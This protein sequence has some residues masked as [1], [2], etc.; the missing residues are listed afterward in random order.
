[1]G[2]W[3]QDR[4]DLI[5]REHHRV[6]GHQII[7][8]GGLWKARCLLSGRAA[9]G[10]LIHA[11]GEVTDV[12]ETAQGIH[13]NL[14]TLQQ[15]LLPSQHLEYWLD[16]QQHASNRQAADK[17]RRLRRA[18]GLCKLRCS[19]SFYIVITSARLAG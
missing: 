16:S 1:M 13:E 7:R 18:V 17:Q 10:E 12:N 6:N 14:D 8:D 3:R 19:T 4:A 11:E 5:R 15:R 2:T 9:A